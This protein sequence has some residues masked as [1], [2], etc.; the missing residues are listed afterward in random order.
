MTKAI[1]LAGFVALAAVA[2][3]APEVFAVSSALARYAVDTYLMIHL[4][5]E[6]VRLACF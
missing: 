4:D 3:W 6:S 2:L 1:G 5:M